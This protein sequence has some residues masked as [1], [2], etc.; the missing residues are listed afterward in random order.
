MKT[1]FHAVFVDV[2]S[3]QD[4]FIEYDAVFSRYIAI[5]QVNDSAIGPV[6]RI[7][8]ESFLELVRTQTDSDICCF[9]GL[10]TALSSFHVNFAA[11]CS[12]MANQ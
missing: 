7:R 9:I 12:M 6:L 1:T 8:C 2:L 11:L 5:I 10:P 3:N 4:I